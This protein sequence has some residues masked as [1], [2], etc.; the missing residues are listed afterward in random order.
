MNHLFWRGTSCNIHRKLYIVIRLRR[1]GFGCSGFVLKFL[2]DCSGQVEH[3]PP[4]L[5]TMGLGCMVLFYFRSSSSR[6]VSS[7]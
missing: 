3:V 7:V 5:I 2:D 6:S 4:M 1:I